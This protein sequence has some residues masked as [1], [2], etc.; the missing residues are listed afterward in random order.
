M[1]LRVQNLLSSLVLAFAC[2]AGCNG[3][4]SPTPQ[5]PEPLAH[6]APQGKRAPCTFGADQTC[7]DDPAVSALWGTCTELGVC[8]CIPGFELSQESKRCRPLR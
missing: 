3:Q 4:S 1:P 5:T 2:T 8:E 7:N 6:D